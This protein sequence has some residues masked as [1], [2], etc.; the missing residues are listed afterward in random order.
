[1]AQASLAYELAPRPLARKW[2]P[3]CA[4]F[5]DLATQNAG[6]N[7]QFAIPDLQFAIGTP[8]HCKL[9]IRNCK[10]QMERMLAP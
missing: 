7:L 8:V 4:A 1:V 2:L 9:Q 5:D 3:G 10:L 6:A